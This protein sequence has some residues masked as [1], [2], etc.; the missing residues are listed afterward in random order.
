MSLRT[1]PALAWLL[2]TALALHGVVPALAAPQGQGGNASAADL[3]RAADRAV[4][5]TVKAAGESGDAKLKQE[6]KDSE[7]F[8]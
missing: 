7:P 8:W 1:R 3:T 2:S 5:F 4:G 6:N